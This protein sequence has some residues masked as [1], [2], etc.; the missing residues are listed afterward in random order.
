MMKKIFIGLAII[1]ALTFGYKT[2][3]YQTSLT[4]DMTF[5]RAN[6][7]SHICEMMY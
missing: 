2:L 5:C 6:F 7:S 4:M 3:M 1:A